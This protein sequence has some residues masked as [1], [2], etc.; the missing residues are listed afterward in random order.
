MSGRNSR[1]GSGPPSIV[2]RTLHLHRRVPLRPGRFARSNA[3]IVPWFRGRRFLCDLQPLPRLLRLE[4]PAKTKY[5]V[6]APTNKKHIYANAHQM[7]VIY[8][9]VFYPTNTWERQLNIIGKTIIFI[10]SASQISLSQ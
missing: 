2:R 5:T 10:Y 7:R 3:S 6:T 8:I 9:P 1:H 4:E